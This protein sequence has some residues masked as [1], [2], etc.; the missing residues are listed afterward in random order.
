MPLSCRTPL[1]KEAL[2]WNVP[3]PLPMKA[4]TSPSATWA[5]TVHPAPATEQPVLGVFAPHTTSRLPS[6]FTS[7]A[8][9]DQALFVVCF[10][11]NTAG[12]ANVPSP[13]PSTHAS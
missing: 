2:S 6:E 13:L 8:V 7:P 10:Q 3:S 4:R 1:T 9:S 5:A 11:G 12:A